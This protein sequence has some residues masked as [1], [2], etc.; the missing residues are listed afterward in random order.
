MTVQVVPWEENPYLWV[1][2]HFFKEKTKH[3]II[4][5]LLAI[6]ISGESENKEPEKTATGFGRIIKI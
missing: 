3:V 1:S 2:E 4:V 5:W 6:W